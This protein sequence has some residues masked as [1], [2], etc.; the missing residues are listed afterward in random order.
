MRKNRTNTN[1]A[2]IRGYSPEKPC[3]RID[4]CVDYESSTKCLESG[5]ALISV[6]IV[7][8]IEEIV[9]SSVCCRIVVL[10]KVSV[11]YVFARA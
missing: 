5:N 9:H 2:K 8:S 11:Y 1:W 3:P 4:A 6:H 7:R 10:W